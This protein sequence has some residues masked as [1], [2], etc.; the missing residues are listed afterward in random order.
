L[1]ELA[2]KNYREDAKNHL[3]RQ[4]A[5]LPRWL[6]SFPDFQNRALC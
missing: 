1:E 3:S 4:L 6:V 5:P 2:V